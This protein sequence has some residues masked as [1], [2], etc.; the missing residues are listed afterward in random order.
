MA[1]PGH[2]FWS[3]E[4]RKSTNSTNFSSRICDRL[5]RQQGD[6]WPHRQQRNLFFTKFRPW[7][8]ATGAF[9]AAQAHNLGYPLSN[10]ITTA[11]AGGSDEE[12]AVCG[13][14]TGRKGFY[15]P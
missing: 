9:T 15:T 6:S 12:H 1:G 3:A 7:P 13:S 5:A 11:P 10:I 4:R 2:I 14:E 8:S